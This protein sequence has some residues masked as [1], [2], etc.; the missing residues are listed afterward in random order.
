MLNVKNIRKSKATTVLGVVLIVAGIASVFT[1]QAS[2]TEASIVIG[3][4]IWLLFEEDPKRKK[5]DEN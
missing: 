5:E 2:W 1:E 4:G 3:A